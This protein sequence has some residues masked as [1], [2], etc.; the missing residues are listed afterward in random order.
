LEIVPDGGDPTRHF[1]EMIDRWEERLHMPPGEL[2]MRLRG[3]NERL[4]SIGKDP[5]LGTCTEEEWQ[6]A[7]WDATG[8]SREQFDAFMRDHWDVYLGN[9][10]EEMM[11]FFKSLRPRYRTALLSNSGVG[12]RR[13]EQQRYHFNE[14][15]DL[16]IYS[17]EEGV[18]KPDR[19]IFAITCER[20]GGSPEEIL[21]LDDAPPN[22]DAAQAYG[23]HAVLFTNTTQAIADIQS[24]LSTL[25]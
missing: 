23:M 6:A 5:G 15:S 8:M 18:A 3:M 17:H 22:V 4:A 2:R 12:A 10:N 13:Q 20:L 16:I 14:M 1:A 24:Y 25:S 7:I 11:A 9:P 21:F 19:R